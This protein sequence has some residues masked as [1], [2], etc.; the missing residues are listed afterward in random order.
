MIT[1]LLSRLRLNSSKKKITG[2]EEPFQSEL[3]SSDQMNR[4]GVAVAKAHSLEKRKTPDRLLQRLAD[5]QLTLLEIRKLLI[6]DLRPENALSPAAEWLLDNY[7]LIEEQMSMAAKHLPRGYSEGLPGLSAGASAGLPRIYDIVLEIIAH[8]DGRVDLDN[9]MGFVASYQTISPLTLGEL[10]AI[11]IMLRLAVIEN[12]RRVCDKI[13]VDKIDHNLAHYWA[14]KMIETVTEKSNNLILI[15]ADMARSKP[16]LGGAFVAGF[17]QK[18][19]GKG[20]VFALPL[21]WLEQQLAT[22]GLNSED[23][24]RDENRKQAS[25]Q[26]SVRNSIGTFRFLSNTDWRKFVEALS[27]VEYVLRQD[28]AGVYPFMDFATK[29]RYRHVIEAIAKASPSSET[30]VARAVLELAATCKRKGTTAKYAHVGYYLVDKG[31]EEAERI[32]GMQYTVN[33]KIAK[34]VHQRPLTVYLGAISFVIIT[35]TFAMLY[36]A[37]M[38]GVY[39][40][41]LLLTGLLSALGASQL[42]ISLVNWV[43]TIVAKPSLLPRMDFSKGIPEVHRTLVV[44]P[45][46]LTDSEYL[47]EQLQS[48]EMHFLANNEVHLHYGLL[49]DFP[50][51]DQQELPGEDLLFEE[52]RKGIMALN[53]KYQEGREQRFFLFHRQ[54]TWNPKASKWM[55]HERKRGKLAALNA[56]LCGREDGQFSGITYAY[57]LL[58]AVRYVLT[59]DSDTQLPKDTIRQLV[60]TMVHPLNRPVYDPVK[61]R[62][63]EGYGILQPRVE[64]NLPQA[65]P[66][67][68]L[69]MLGS[70]EGIDP[71]TRASSDVYQDLFGEGSFIGKGIY[72]VAIF[73]QAL[74]GL[75]EENRILSHDLLEGC[76]ARSGLVSDII[77]YEEAPTRYD[78][79]IRRRHR[80]VRGDWQIGAW[81]LPIVTNYQGQLIKNKLSALS[82]WKI[83]DNIRRSLMPI[84]LLS[85]LLLGWTVLPLPWFWTLAV[86]AFVLFSVITAV[87]W[88]LLNKPTTLSF[89]AHL[90]EVGN[91]FDDILIRFLVDIAVLPYEALKNCD[92]IV[93]ANWR[94]V[95]SRKNLLEWTPS[96]LVSDKG[97]TSLISAYWMM[98]ITPFLALACGVLLFWYSPYALGVAAPILILWLLAPAVLWYLSKP[99]IEKPPA[100]TKQQLS[101]LHQSARKTWSFFEQ[102]VTA[103]ENWL[104]P[105]NLQEHPN[106]IIAHRTSPTNMGLSLLA[107][108]TAYDF[109]YLTGMDLID[110]CD[111]SLQV[112]LQLERYQGHFYNWYNTL[113]LSPLAPRY[114]STVDSGNLAGHLLTLRQGLL[115]LPEQLVFDHNLLDGLKTT[116]VLV[117][118]SAKGQNAVIA[119][120]V[121]TLLNAT[122]ASPLSLSDLKACLDELR[123]LVQAFIQDEEGSQPA[124]VSWE[125][126]LIHQLESARMDLEQ[127]VPWVGLLPIPDRFAALSVADAMPSL[128]A[129]SGSTE[130]LMAQVD[131]YKMETDLPEEVAWLDALSGSLALGQKN[132]EARLL[133]I[134]MLTER[135]EQLSD[136]EYHFLVDKSTHLCAI[137]FNVDLQMRDDSYYDLLASE[138]RLGIF[139]AIAQGKLPEESWFALGR[140]LT[141]VSG[142]PVLLS[143]SG[144][145]FEYLMPQ[146]VMPVY[147]NTLLHHTGKITVKKQIE[148]AAQ[149][150]KPWGIS[151]SAF[152]TVDANLNYQYR[153]FGVPGLGLKRG[154]EDDL[155]IA[156]YASMLALMVSPEKACANLQVLAAQGLEGEFGFY[157]AVDYTASRQP[158]GKSHTIIQSFMVHHQGM[159]LLALAYLLLNRPMQR[160][161][162]ADLRF[163]ALLLLLQE[164]IPRAVPF[165][166]HTESIVESYHAD[167]DMLVRSVPTP[168]TAIPEIQL[169]SNGRYQVV[170]S[171][172]G[173]GYSRWA[174]LAVTRW[175]EDITKDNYGIFCYIKDVDSG[176]FWSNAHQPTLKQGKDY[177][178]VFSNGHVEFHRQDYGIVTKTEIV[179]S[180]EDDVEMRRVRLINKTAGDRVL[181]ITSYAEVTLASQASD[182][183][184]PAFSNLFVQTEIMPEHNAIVCSRRPRSAE[185]RPPWMFHLM[186]VHGGPVESVSYETDRMQFLG[187]GRTPVYP[188]AM[189]TDVLSGQDGPVLDPVLAIRYRMVIKSGQTATIDLIYGIAEEEQACADLVH[190]YRDQHIRSRAFELSWTHSQV[191]LR[192]INAKEKDVQLYNRLAASIIYANPTFRAEAAIIRKNTKGQSGL[193]SQSISGDLP[194]VV[195]HIHNP[196][197]IGLVRQI[198]QAHA[199]WRINGLEVDLIIWNEDHGAYRQLL[200][201]HILGLITEAES[202]VAH[203]RLGNIYVRVA[204]HLPE[205]D[206]VLFDSVARLVLHARN[207]R[208]SEQLNK[209]SMEAQLPPLLEPKLVEKSGASDPVSLPE[210]LLFFNGTGGFT[211]DGREYKIR[212]S[213]NTSTPAPWVNVLANRDF[214]TV[215][216]ESGSA[217]T[218]ALNAHEYRLSP[219]TNDPVSD[220][221][222]EA[223]YL[224]DEDTGKFWSPSP[225]PV[226]ETGPYITTHG[227]GY[228]CFEHAAFGVLSE[229]IIYVDVALPV[230]YIVLK[231]KNQSGRD[232]P[233]SA[234]GFMEIVLGKVR[235]ET[236]MHILPERD[237]DNGALLFRNRYNTPFAERVAFFKTDHPNHSFT[238]DRS[239]FIGRNGSLKRPLALLR[240]TLSGRCITGIDTCAAL[241][242]KFALPKGSEK[243]II[244]QLGSAENGAALSALM[245]QC[246]GKEAANSAF[247]AVKAHWKDIQGAI[248]IHTPD[249]ALNL[250]A[251]G[252]LSY[253]ILSSRIFARSGFYQSGGAFGFR[254][255]LQDVLALL[256]TQPDMAKQQI[257]LHASRQFT[258]GDVQHWWHP[259]EGKGVRTRCSDDLLWLPYTVACY[260]TATG[261]KDILSR[262]VP[263]LESRLLRL[264]EDAFYDLPASGNQ[265]GTLYEHCVRAIKHSAQ[266]GVHGLPLIG[267]GDW[268]DGMDRVG[269]KGQGESVWLGFFFYDVLV[270]FSA[271]AKV[272]GDDA[273][274]AW[275]LRE[276]A[277]LQ[278]NI[279][280]TGW[281]GEWYLRAWF[282]DG[283]PLGTKE[284]IECSIDAIAQSWSVLSG[285]AG[286]ERAESA[287]RSLVQYLVEKDMK[288][289]RLLKPPFNQP[290][291]LSPGYIK[292]YV[293]GV[294]EN[295]GQYTHAAIWALMAF[296]KLK[297]RE[298]VW[299]LFAMINP[300]NQALDAKASAIYKVEPYVMAA[301]VYANEAHQGRGGWTWYTGSAGWMYQFITQ[302]LLGME[303]AADTLKF[304]PCFPLQWPAVTIHYRYGK[305]MYSITL[306]QIHTGSS[307]WRIDER[308]GAG[309]QIL[310]VDDGRDHNVEVYILTGK[311]DE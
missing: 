94:M 69:S 128:L 261:D 177:S 95:V 26:V 33:Q 34:A 290:D 74:Q 194:I 124:M 202:N 283:T 292:G 289:I 307:W 79:D 139:V 245:Q 130:L 105:D 67:L 58:K 191:L 256:S 301:D 269:N 196:E 294:R 111:H 51:A 18:L 293:P 84:T 8:S 267:S 287:M 12:L 126:R 119:E 304:D 20:T 165:Y 141:K 242:V 198:V 32:S 215:L 227:F 80:W 152:N 178:A 277:T 29:D 272:Y 31:K 302:S 158:R 211:A 243:E 112:M 206:R 264:E 38:N 238:T 137:G 228:T 204:G 138:A 148:Y 155:V 275:C 47:D 70:I 197:H 23:L 96:A 62:V 102:F 203:N 180:P 223:F 288:L 297:Q 200:Q 149:K 63:T 281:D 213:K 55:G 296:S 221:G 134:Q 273:F 199:Y 156:P 36:V 150:G 309:N 186:E 170:V 183:A 64:S 115:S 92:A 253:Q 255:Q 201:E 260:T 30:E 142:D 57:N 218:W 257:L 6:E 118:E 286:K 249:E 237:V 179:V 247:D 298:K 308:K 209:V 169:L 250:L 22:R 278:T 207:G 190:K 73:E 239:E 217:Y 216:S 113:T 40:G 157:E 224:R 184:H 14:D 162:I 235:S 258:E 262:S 131:Q 311:T 98:G 212:T 163:Q 205:E 246:S 21:N 232:R 90:I 27:T 291:G 189:D 133:K 13:V 259:P 59:L 240:E 151:E 39:G 10:W 99:I 110:R 109:G 15:M 208:L 1:D 231:I 225:F 164:R 100:L 271:I 44:I 46:M 226:G 195:V 300:I 145:M 88:Q 5:N 61:K 282:D 181:E 83:A 82:K 48:L 144:S 276:A 91:H 263:Y 241:Q 65:K 60:G 106:K 104:P 42:A 171:N 305:S 236:T 210:K 285:A 66:S 87:F 185:E 230:K 229:L 11:P 251:N 43:V 244:F 252:W 166:V 25:Y 107:N 37:R 270:R 116:T 153:A 41:L 182:E 114:I 75:F 306:S 19:Q 117:L 77:L 16:V 53:L 233:L 188:Q 147:E 299:E 193:W 28:P 167:A 176:H 160:R 154:L 310:L 9:L 268:N 68:Y 140:Q 49:T 86:T 127:I 56:L 295:G 173:G 123:T 234:T 125:T 54:R 52:A 136:A 121:L 81:M 219:W 284:N 132:A 174:G 187:R 103:E 72:D 120:Q 45:T 161:F 122:S 143:W 93:R 135:C 248:R 303:L 254:D 17:I 7:Y 159:G 274:S 222:G 168:N 220:E 214:G 172:S 279:E 146:L 50:D 4:H 24:I 175:R 280:R 78:A 89:K 2:K 35:I 85:I 101:F 76:Y 266:F 192:Q 108:L 71:Y 129:I 3:Y 265:R 97:R